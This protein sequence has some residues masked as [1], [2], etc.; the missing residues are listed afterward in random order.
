MTAHQFNIA[1]EDLLQ[2]MTNVLDHTNPLIVN[3]MVK[4]HHLEPKPTIM[5]TTAAV[6]A[7]AAVKRR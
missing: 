1:K 7:T 4:K 3:N 2:K 5:K 6:A